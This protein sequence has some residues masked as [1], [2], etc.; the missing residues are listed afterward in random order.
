LAAN[1]QDSAIKLRIN[2]EE[3]REMEEKYE[4]REKRNDEL[5]GK[6]L[7]LEEDYMV[8]QSRTHMDPVSSDAAASGSADES[9]R[10]ILW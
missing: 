7:R 1:A 4:H 6:Y 5:M 10:I 2:Q 9:R 3:K 8:L